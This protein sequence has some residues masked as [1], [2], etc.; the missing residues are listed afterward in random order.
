MR[1]PNWV[2]FCL[3]GM[4]LASVILFRP[5]ET[6]A[7]ALRRTGP[8]LAVAGGPR[9]LPP[10]DA[11]DERVVVDVEAP[12]DGLGTAFAINQAGYWLTARHVAEGC[13]RLGIV[14][15]GS[16]ILAVDDVRLS[17]NADLALLKTDRAP[18]ALG[19][20]LDPSLSLGD[21]GFH[22]GFPQGVR[23]E[24]SSQLVGRSSLVTRGRYATEEPVLAWTE[25]GRTLD[26]ALM[27]SGMSGGPVLNG[28]GRA[29]GV[30]VAQS[31][32]R[33]RIYTVS[34]EAVARFLEQQGVTADAGQSIAISEMTVRSAA[35]RLRR[36]QAVVKI[37]C[38]V[39]G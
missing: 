22:V 6:S 32:E 20:E 15:A 8:E 23:G 29:I 25:T 28:D 19:L 11:F 33:G 17:R 13:E 16:R 12:S 26:P 27:L 37:I 38:Q 14:V 7:P 10:A 3:A 30:V 35:D 36:D 39:E 5:D 34:P 9:P 31:P 4:A 21:R 2:V 1:I 24:A 18:V